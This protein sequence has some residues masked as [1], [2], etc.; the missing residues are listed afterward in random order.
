MKKQRAK[1]TDTVDE[2]GTHHGIMTAIAFGLGG[3][4]VL[5]DHYENKGQ[6]ELVNSRELPTKTSSHGKSDYVAVYDKMGI[7]VLR[8]KPGDDMFC[9]AVLPQGWK[10]QRTD[11]SMWSNLLDDKGR[12]RAQIFYKASPWD[13]DAFLS[14][15]RRFNIDFHKYLSEEEKFLPKK[16]IMVDEEIPMD[17]NDGWGRNT[18][19]DEEGYI[20]MHDGHNRILRSKKK[21]TRKVP[22]EVTERRYANIYEET[23]ATPYWIEVKDSDGTVL[24]STEKQYFKTPYPVLHKEGQ[25]QLWTPEESAAHYEWWDKHKAFEDLQYSLGKLWLDQHYPNWNDCNAYWDIEIPKP[26]AA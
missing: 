2:L 6:R 21:M 23:M 19:V 11:H 12:R 22:K 10:V 5:A 18:Y 15:D 25:H 17:S 8:E 24:F 3:G 26:K 13:R 16:T 20:V 14:P 1:I 7:K 9:E 4:Q